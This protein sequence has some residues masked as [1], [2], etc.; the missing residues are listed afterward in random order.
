[1]N[2]NVPMI[3]V[4]LFYKSCSTLIGYDEDNLMG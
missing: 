1:M 3:S 4:V 2:K